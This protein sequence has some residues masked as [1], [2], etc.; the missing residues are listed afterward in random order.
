MLS[1]FILSVMVTLK[2]LHPSLIYSH[3]T[4]QGIST[5]GAPLIHSIHQTWRQFFNYF[6]RTSLLRRNEIYKNWPKR[7][8]AITI[9]AGITMLTWATVI[10]LFSLSLRTLQQNKLEHLYSVFFQDGLIRVLLSVKLEHKFQ[11]LDWHKKMSWVKTLA[12]F[13]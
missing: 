2:H 8:N 9:I 4:G 12:Y 13:Y 11:I 7:S 1:V 10:K 6:K 5:V 3:D